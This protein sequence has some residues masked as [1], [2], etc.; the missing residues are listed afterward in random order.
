MKIVMI[1]SGFKEC[2]DAEEVGEAMRMG[3]HRLNLDASITVIPMIDGGEGFA[4]SIVN[5]KHGRLYHKEVTGPVGQPITSYFG[6]YTENNKKTAVIEMAAVAGLKLV[7][8]EQRNPLWTTTYGVGELILGALDFGVDHIL[9]GCGDSGT[10]DG[11]AGMAQALGAVFTD[12][13]GQP[14]YI[15]GGG[16]L[17]KVR[18]IDLADLDPRLTDV[19]IDVACNW[20]NVLC[21]RDG[22]AHVFGPQKG[23]TA[24]EVEHLASAFQHY[25]HL[26][27]NQLGVDIALAPGS[28]ASGG[29]G[30]GLVAFANAK[31]H[32]RYEVIMQYINIEQHILEADVV[33]TAEGCLDY[34]T[35]NGKI[36]SEV[37]RIAKSKGI[38]VIA[39]TGTIGENAAINYENGIDAYA[40]IIQTPASL[41][42]AILNATPWIADSTE[43]ALRH[44]RIGYQIAHRTLNEG[45][46]PL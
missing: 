5:I 45:Y 24:E 13:A 2:L 33:L 6:I 10:S 32:P 9:I 44:V 29:L 14:V 34:Q 37:A 40:S 27:H 18:S 30:A 17:A 25:A 8:R 1:P 11:G 15:R 22:V 35:P 31:L 7:P 28:G 43:A 41:D 21:G 36:P 4:K 3:V 23:A 38:P 16:D 20:H 12:E 26:I 46:R 39:I 42:Q 19:H